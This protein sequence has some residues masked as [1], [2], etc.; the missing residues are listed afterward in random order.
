[1]EVEGKVA[2]VSCLK[3]GLKI[4]LHCIKMLGQLLLVNVGLAWEQVQRTSL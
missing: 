1:M 3:E 2:Y 4:F